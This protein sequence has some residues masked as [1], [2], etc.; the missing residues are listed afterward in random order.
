MRQ[1]MRFLN[2]VLCMKT[3]RMVICTIAGIL[4]LVAP[5]SPKA[6]P[7]QGQGQVIVT[8]LPKDNGQ[9]SPSLG[10]QD[11]Q[12]KVGGK[13]T[14]V[15]DWVFLRE[16]D[17]NVEMVILIDGSARP[18]LG[19]QL[20]DIANFIQSLPANA[21]IAVGSMDSGRAVL[22]GQISTD[23]AEVASRLRLPGGM[24][25]SS[26]SPYFCLSDLAKHWPSKD[27]SAR[28]EVVLL[29][30]GVD[31]YYGHYDPEDPYL[32]AAINDSIRAGLVVD[33]IYWSGRG[34]R[35]DSRS[36][37]FDGQRLLSQLAQ[38]TGGAFYF[39]GTGEPVSLSPYFDDISRRLQNQFRLTFQ[40][41]LKG[42]PE[43]RNLS[44][45]TSVPAIDLYAPQ[46]VFVKQP[47]RE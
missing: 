14:S 31:E 36:E 41:P 45:K 17:N 22:S 20:N 7:D 25:G 4:V 19:Q 9:A 47:S 10:S 32:E 24:A 29:T 23:H 12:L 13:E 1:A 21:K 33:S 35:N 3:L 46:R 34:H 27:Q 5:A 18:S 8:I 6:I 42:K 28:R 26:S 2:G 11:L 39:N 15:R 40:T 37:S 44:L 43:V 30:N 38:A 16:P